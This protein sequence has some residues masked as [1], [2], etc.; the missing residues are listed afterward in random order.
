MRWR[1]FSAPFGNACTQVNPMSIDPACE[2]LMGVRSLLNCRSISRVKQCMRGCHL[3][4]VG[5]I[6]HI[7]QLERLRL[8]DVGLVLKS[9]HRPDC[10]RPNRASLIEL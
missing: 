10:R 6:S 9:H 5:D 7:A 1:V 3:E 8:N 4:S 2:C